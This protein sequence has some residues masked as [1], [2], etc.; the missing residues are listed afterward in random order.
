MDPRCSGIEVKELF[1][2]SLSTGGVS[3][4]HCFLVEGTRQRN[5]KALLA[6]PCCD[7]L[8]SRIE[9]FV[10]RGRLEREE[11]ENGE[12]VHRGKKSKHSHSS[13]SPH[14]ATEVPSSNT[15]ADK[16]MED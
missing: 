2:S 13:A 6:R 10:K 12:M 1:F 9:H 3:S 8:E 4:S 11:G 14:V 7:S 5:Y 15:N 16:Q